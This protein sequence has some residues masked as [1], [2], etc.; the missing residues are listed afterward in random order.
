MIRATFMKC[1]VS[2]VGADAMSFEMAAVARYKIGK[3]SSVQNLINIH[4]KNKKIRQ[5][6][7]QFV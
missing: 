6:K 4:G 3:N 1:T 7:S 5:S 2:P